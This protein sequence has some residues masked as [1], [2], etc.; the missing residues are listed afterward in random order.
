MHVQTELGGNDVEKVVSVVRAAGGS[1]IGRTRLQKTVYLLERAGFIDGFEFEYRH[2]GPYSEDLSHATIF[3][4]MSGILEEEE[5]S[6]S[7]GGTYSIF[8]ATGPA[9]RITPEMQ[10]MIDISMN[11]NPIALELAATAAF[12]ANEGFERP[13]EETEKRKIDKARYIEDAKQVYSKLAS[14]E[15]PNRLPILAC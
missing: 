7:W 8:K 15:T 12:L 14:I 9:P 1:L 3:A 10:L 13:W 5:R 11:S 6:A 2:Y 4:R